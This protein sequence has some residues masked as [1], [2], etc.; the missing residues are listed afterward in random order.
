MVAP[1]DVRVL[2]KKRRVGGRT[3]HL[4]RGDRVPV[5]LLTYF[6][7]HHS[8]SAKTILEA[9]DSPGPRSPPTE[10]HEVSPREADNVLQVEFLRESV[11]WARPSF[12]TLAPPRRLEGGWAAA[13]RAA[14]R[15]CR[16]ALAEAATAVGTADSRGTGLP[17]PIGHREP[18]RPRYEIR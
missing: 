10:V 6:I 15:C 9:L 3:S 16:A 11:R 4:A 12:P 2:P 17:N 18:Q 7:S 14:A 5:H 1:R 13:G 8:T